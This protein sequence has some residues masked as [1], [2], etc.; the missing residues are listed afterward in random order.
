[1]YRV[2]GNGP[3]PG[4]GLVRFLRCIL[5]ERAALISDRDG[6]GSREWG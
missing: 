3:G 4:P 1:M 5:A 2:V 6:S